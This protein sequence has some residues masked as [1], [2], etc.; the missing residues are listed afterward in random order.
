MLGLSD[1]SLDPR[2]VGLALMAAFSATGQLILVP[3]IS[4]EVG[5]MPV[6]AFATAV[7]AA[8]LFAV[9][10]MDGGALPTGVTGWSSLG[11]M[12]IAHVAGVY[13]LFKALL[14]LG[15]TRTAIANNLEPLVSITAAALILGQFL[16]PMQA[17]GGALI[18]G[19][20]ILNQYDPKSPS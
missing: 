5:T 8:V 19:A 11:V 18:L 9:F 20:V 16:G 1:I 2:G 15:P 6:V 4:A 14:Y 7:I 12:A 13:L 3:R 17:L 10:L